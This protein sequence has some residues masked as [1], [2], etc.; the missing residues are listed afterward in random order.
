MNIERQLLHTG[1]TD[2]QAA[3]KLFDAQHYNQA[4]FLF[5]QAVEKCV[6]S[7]GLVTK[8]IEEKDLAGK[9]SH[10]PHKVFTREFKKKIDKLHKSKKYDNFNS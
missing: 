7:Y 10:L 4:V 6:K 2:L 5:Q 8:V 9:I 3:I 1:K